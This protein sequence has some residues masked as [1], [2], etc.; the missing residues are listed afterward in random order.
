VSLLEKPKVFTREATGLVREISAFGSFGVAITGV[1]VI[2]IFLFYEYFMISTG[3]NPLL[4]IALMAVPFLALA[5][6]WAMLSMTFP[7][8]G[9]DYVFNS[10]ALHPTLAV[11]GDFLLVMTLP[12]VL[13]A[14]ISIDTGF[15]SDMLSIDGFLTGNT[16]LTSIGSSLG[17]QSVQFV[18]M[19]LAVI[20]TLF[21]LV[22][23]TKIFVQTQAIVQA[24]NILVFLVLM[25]VLAATSNAAY[26]AQ[27]TNVF[28]IDYSSILTSAQKGGFT[29]PTLLGLSL[30][31]TSF[32][33][34]WQP[35]P[36]WAAHVG[37]ETRRPQKTLLYSIVG[38]QLLMIVLFLIAGIVCFNTYGRA[39]S[40][41]ANYLA[42]GANNPFP[43][44]Q[45]NFLGLMVP[46]LADPILI[47]I[48][49]IIMILGGYFIGAMAVMSITRH[50]FAWS[51]DRLIPAKFS[52][53]SDRFKT[54]VWGA[55]L[56]AII[57][58]VYGILN[59]YGPGVFLYVSALGPIYSGV[60]WGLSSLAGVFLPLK[61]NLFE[62]APPLVR[63]KIGGIPVLSLISAFSF[64]T[65]IGL[66]I[67]GQIVPAVQGGLPMGPLIWTLIIFFAGIPFYYLVKAYRLKHDG[68]DLSLVYK[69]IPPD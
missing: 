19:T 63:K 12:G 5:A 66:L 17:S 28:K 52:E 3:D 50:V 56:V 33:I 14:F 62:Q 31:G 54:P 15:L 48:V 43:M 60:A 36:Q 26:Q 67:L 10:R 51:F 2:S 65:I 55:L 32:L 13:T 27:F 16:G 30:F 1:G 21:F 42:F 4:S 49:F 47:S 59:I 24:L 44:S 57:A 35:G 18:I 46:V 69:Q 29:A 34:F 6:A 45:A 68:F 23:R 7:R 11:M 38:A 64:V 41:A 20:V 40:Y 37:G 9:G 58:E 22:G 8:S 25:A 53:V 39:F 61:K